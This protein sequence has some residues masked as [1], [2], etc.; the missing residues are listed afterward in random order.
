MAPTQSVKKYPSAYGHGFMTRS[1]GVKGELDTHKAG[2][3]FK[4]YQKKEDEV[5]ANYIVHDREHPQ[6]P[7]HTYIA[8]PLSPLHYGVPLADGPDPGV[9]AVSN[10]LFGGSP[11]FTPIPITSKPV[12]RRRQRG[13]SYPEWSNAFVTRVDPCECISPE[14]TYTPYEV[15][16]YRDSQGRKQTLLSFNA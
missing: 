8:G 9:S 15:A 4:G 5:Q 2:H 16:K 1:E 10:A 13:D 3:Y 14:E 6:A 11:A 7:P 12:F